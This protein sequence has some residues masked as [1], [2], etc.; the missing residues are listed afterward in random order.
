MAEAK[1]Q[2]IKLLSLNILINITEVLPRYPE[3]IGVDP[4]D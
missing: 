3:P 4:K 2:D 1:D